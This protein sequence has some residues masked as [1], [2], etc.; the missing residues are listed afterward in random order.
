[1]CVR[2]RVYVSVCL[3]VCVCKCNT[4][5][6]IP[7]QQ[8]KQRFP[9]C[10]KVGAEEVLV[11]LPWAS[12]GPPFLPPWLPARLPHKLSALCPK[13]V[14]FSLTLSAMLSFKFKNTHLFH[15]Q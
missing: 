11:S 3:C 7:G 2:T 4:F 12:P 10:Q 14:L 6:R 9:K 13:S 8:W 15:E 1:M 5:L